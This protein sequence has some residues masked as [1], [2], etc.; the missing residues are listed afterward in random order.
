MKM[1]QEEAALGSDKC[2]KKNGDGPIKVAPKIYVLFGA[3]HLIK[4]INSL[5]SMQSLFFF[6]FLGVGMVK[7]KSSH[8][9]DMFLKEFPIAPGFYPKCFGKCCPPFTDIGRPMGRNSI[10]QNRNFYFQEPP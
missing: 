6:W 2:F 1:G 8:V 10:L 4:R 7:V 5:L 3:P 9:P